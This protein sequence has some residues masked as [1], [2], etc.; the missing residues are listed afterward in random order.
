[1]AHA[2]VVQVADAH[3]QLAEVLPRHLL[4]EPA[5]LLGVELVDQIPL[6]VG[7]DRVSGLASLNLSVQ[8]S[9]A[10]TLVMYGRTR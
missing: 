4:G 7:P 9:R 1:M 3:G 2:L 8:C 10:L 6:C 5:P